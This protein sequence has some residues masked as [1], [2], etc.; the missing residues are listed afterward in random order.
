MGILGSGRQE[1]QRTSPQEG[2]AV[3]GHRASGGCCDTTKE[4]NVRRVRCA[5]QQRLSFAAV[6]ATRAAVS[7]DLNL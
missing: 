7:H 6:S 2:P 4:R 1:G 3:Q 5:R